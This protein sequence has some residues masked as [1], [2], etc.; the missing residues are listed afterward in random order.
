MKYDNNNLNKVIPS[1]AG[2]LSSAAIKSLLSK[3]EQ[4]IIDC[5]DGVSSVEGIAICLGQTPARLLTRLHLLA[6]RGVILLQ[7]KSDAPDTLY[8][9]P[10]LSS[11]DA[12]PAT[13][14]M[15]KPKPVPTSPPNFFETIE[16]KEDASPSH[17]SLHD[18]QSTDIDDE[19]RQT[20][21]TAFRSEFTPL[22]LVTGRHSPIEPSSFW[23]WDGDEQ[24]HFPERDN[25]SL[26]AFTGGEFM[27]SQEALPSA[28]SAELGPPHQSDSS[29]ILPPI[30]P[31]ENKFSITGDLPVIKGSLILGEGEGTEEADE[32]QSEKKEESPSP[33]KEKDES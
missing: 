15:L 21:I 31:V 12:V 29:P 1:L 16:E 17:E 9:Q 20:D 13:D 28:S 3:E 14:P 7:E 10:S 19:L 2:Q 26:D 25:F 11:L 18:V 23:D 33:T 32:A 30:T 22:P 5:I 8:E 24:N 6:A 4:E 27:P